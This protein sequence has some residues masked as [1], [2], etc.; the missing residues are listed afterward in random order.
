MRILF[1]I[2][3][4][5]FTKVSLAS[6]GDGA[7]VHDTSIIISK[8]NYRLSEAEFLKKYGRD[9]SSRALIQYYFY[10]RGK[11]KKIL[12][13]PLATAAS[14]ATTIGIVSIFT[15]LSL[16]VSS[17]IGFFAVFLLTV[18]SLAILSLCITGT[19]M[20][21]FNG[22]KK[23]LVRL[24]NYYSGGHIP[25]HLARSKIFHQLLKTGKVANR[26][27]IHHFLKR[28]KRKEPPDEWH[29]QTSDSKNNKSFSTWNLKPINWW[30]NLSTQEIV[31]T[32]QLAN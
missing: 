8:N 14:A 20:L 12:F 2:V 4:I 9:D 27:L 30:G 1:S 24:N 6:I 3:F 29:P 23:L 19:M 11:E 28:T 26:H 16:S 32:I 5:F 7:Y 21:I 25:V 10:K 13:V 18:A 31:F 22:R 15:S 17:L